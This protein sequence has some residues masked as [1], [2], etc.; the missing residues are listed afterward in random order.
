MKQCDC[1]FRYS[2]NDVRVCRR[3]IPLCIADACLH[4]VKYD[5]YAQPGI[6]NICLKKVIDISTLRVAALW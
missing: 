3:F 2:R 1:K 4:N 6:K 5:Y